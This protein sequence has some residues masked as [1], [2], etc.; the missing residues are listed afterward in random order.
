R[1]LLVRNTPGVYQC[2]E[3]ASTPLAVG[4]EA[5]SARNARLQALSSMAFIGDPCPTKRT[6]KRGA[7]GSRAIGADLCRA[8]DLAHAAGAAVRDR[9]GD[10]GLGVHDEGPVARHGLADRR[11]REQQ[12]SAWLF[13]AGDG[14]HSNRR[15][16]AE[17]CELA[18][19]DRRIAFADSH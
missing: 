1:V 18:V 14:T 10:L 2:A 4:S 12:E 7:T 5:A 19:A 11:S 9:R 15:P 3:I 17:H 16:T 6:G 13:G 8:R